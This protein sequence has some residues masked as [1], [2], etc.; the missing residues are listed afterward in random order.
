MVMSLPASL[1]PATSSRDPQRGLTQQ[2]HAQQGHA[3]QG[4]AQQ[5]ES[6]AYTRHLLIPGPVASVNTSHQAK[7]LR[8]A[9]ALLD[10]KASCSCFMVL[11]HKVSRANAR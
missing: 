7:V 1:L 9:S 8:S 5:A 3:R 11:L 6:Q 2:G 10:L 4:L